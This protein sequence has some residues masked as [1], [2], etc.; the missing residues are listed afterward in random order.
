MRQFKFT[1][2]TDD[3]HIHSFPLSSDGLKRRFTGTSEGSSDSLSRFSP[4]LKADVLHPLDLGS[5]LWVVI[6]WSESPGVT[7]SDP[8]LLPLKGTDTTGLRLSGAAD[9]SGAHDDGTPDGVTS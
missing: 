7:G 6:A 9:L 4:H 3:H 5:R 1:I 2:V 8:L